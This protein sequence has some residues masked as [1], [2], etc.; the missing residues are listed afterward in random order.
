[1]KQCLDDAKLKAFRH[2]WVSKPDTEKELTI[3]GFRTLTYYE[4]LH[5]LRE[6]QISNLVT[7]G[8]FGMSYFHKKKI[9]DIQK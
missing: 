4:A 2:R 7:N 1:M 6:R 8:Q 5:A 9:K 3:R